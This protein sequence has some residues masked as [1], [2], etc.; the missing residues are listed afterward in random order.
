[1][2]ELRSPAQAGAPVPTRGFLVV[3][4]QGNRKVSGTSHWDGYFGYHRHMGE[5]ERL[6]I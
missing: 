1:L 5:G 3:A 2:G 6:S 4:T